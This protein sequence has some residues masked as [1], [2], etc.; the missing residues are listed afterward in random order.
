M[1]FA[2]EKIDFLVGGVHCI[3]TSTAPPRSHL[4]SDDLLADGLLVLVEEGDEVLD[5]AS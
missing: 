1:L 3:A 4:R 2:N 5:P